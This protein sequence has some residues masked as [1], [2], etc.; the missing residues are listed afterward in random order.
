MR[1]EVDWID[2]PIPMMGAAHAIGDGVPG[3]VV[4]VLVIPDP[5]Q[6]HGWREYYVREDPK[7]SR[8]IGFRKPGAR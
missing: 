7:P 1:R 2:T 8:P 6:R 3:R 5:E 4:G